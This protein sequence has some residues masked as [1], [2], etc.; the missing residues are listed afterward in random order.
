MSAMN[1]PLLL[2][3]EVIINVTSLASLLMI[4]LSLDT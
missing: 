4:S 3:A 1:K 2:K